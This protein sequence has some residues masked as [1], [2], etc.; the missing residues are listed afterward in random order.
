MST[1]PYDR[2]FDPPA[3]VIEVMLGAPGVVPDL[4]VLALLG[5]GADQTVIPQQVATQLGLAQ[6]DEVDIAGIERVAFRSGVYL[7]N[8]KFP[9]LPTMELEV[10]S[11]AGTYSLVGRDLLNRLF[12]L[13]SG[14]EQQLTIEGATS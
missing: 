1:H 9:E 3:P 2:N 10:L 7:V 6:L 13:L 11:W 4:G 8:V 14:P 5:S 12:I